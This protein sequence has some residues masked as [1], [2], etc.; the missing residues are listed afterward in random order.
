[1]KKI[2]LSLLVLAITIPAVAQDPIVKLHEVIIS[3]TTY[4]YLS[5]A[6]SED[7]AIQVSELQHKVANYDVTEADFY[8]DDY[9]EYF[10]TFYIPEGKVLAAYDKDGNILRTV[11]KYKNIN[12]PK[13]VK[14]SILMSYPNWTISKDIYLVN[15]HL[16]KGATKKYKLKLESGDKTLRIKVDEYGNIQ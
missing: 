14:E 3:A 6:G 1:M 10:V 9:D 12:L 11:E 8:R 16:D 2:L 13:A 7:E 5:R 4:K 15:Y